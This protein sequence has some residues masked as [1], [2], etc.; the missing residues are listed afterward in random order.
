[1]AGSRRAPEG[2]ARL[3]DAERSRAALLD[4]AQ[5][6]FADH[7]LAGAR[8]DD[9]AARAGL[10]KQLISYYFG[11]K[12]GLYNAIIERWYAQEREFDAP[13]TTLVDLVLRYLQSGY[14]GQHLQR[15]FLRETLDQDPTTVAYEPDSAEVAGLRERQ[16]AGEIAAELDPAF[17][18]LFLPAMVASGVMFPG[19]AKRLTG[20][21]PTTQDFYERAQDQLSRIVKRLAQ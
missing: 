6:E 11:G 16:Q 14:D 20:L 17:V 1:M 18:L 3:R 5:I 7:G 9:I 13:G 10:N 19:D 12:Q 21:D 15:M 4:A 2:D 8:V